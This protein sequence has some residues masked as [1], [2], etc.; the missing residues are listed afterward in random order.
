MFIRSLTSNLDE[1]IEIAV[2][3]LLKPSFN[4][5]DFNRLKAQTIEGIKQSKKNAGSLAWDAFNRIMYGDNNP[6]SW[7]GSGTIETV[8][9][10][11]LEDYQSFYEANYSPKIASIMAVSNLGEPEIEKA[12]APFSAWSGEDVAVAADKPYPE[13]KTG[14]LYFI[15]KDDAAQSEIRIGKRALPYDALGEFYRAGLMNYA[16]G[17]AFNSRINLNLREDKGYTYGAR[18]FFDGEKT[19]GYYVASSGVKKD[20]TAE[21]IIEFVKEIKGYHEDGIT[22]EE[23]AFTKSAIGQRDARAYETPRQKLGFIS[24]MVNYNLEAEFVDEQSDILSGF[25]KAEADALAQKHLDVSEMVMVVV[26]DKA[27]IMDD[28][29]ALGYPIVELDADGNPVK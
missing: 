28:V 13:L 21:S 7:G 8:N 23:L 5:E 24:R 16:L 27:E 11:T 25:T 17:G 10:T 3:K 12:L 19:R 20:K 1:T 15:N 9:N 22:S 2:E 26:G 6:I 4:D 29:K 18:S 14:T